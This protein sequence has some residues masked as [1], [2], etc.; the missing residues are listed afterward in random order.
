MENEILG[1]KIKIEIMEKKALEQERANKQKLTLVN[2]LN[3]E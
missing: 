3:S 2:K 1:N